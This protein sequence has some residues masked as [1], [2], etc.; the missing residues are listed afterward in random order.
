MW[1]PVV[2]EDYPRN[3]KELEAAFSTKA[4][5]RDYLARLR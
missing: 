2:I 5:C 4:V 3:L 1:Y